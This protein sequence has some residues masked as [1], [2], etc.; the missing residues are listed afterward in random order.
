MGTTPGNP[1]VIAQWNIAQSQLDAVNSDIGGMTNLANEI[2]NNVTVAGF[3]L[4]AIRSSYSL[5]GGIDQDHRDLDQ[6]ENA[7]AESLQASTQM[8]A[9]I[10]AEIAQQAAYVSSERQNLTSL[11]QAIDKGH[12]LNAPGIAGRSLSVG[13]GSQVASTAARRPLVVIRFDRDN[14]NYQNALA[15]AVGQAI[16]RFPSA[17]FDL[18]AISPASA[19]GSGQT[20]R[21]H[22][23]G[24][25]RSL[26]GMGIPAARIT[27]SATSS[28]AAAV[29][30][31]HIYVR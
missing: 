30:E 31:V 17:Q 9:S 7:T 22:A 12:F 29:D 3:L 13:A 26:T 25:M 19:P 6:L 15:S 1:E 21:R 20:A 27:M 10:N 24:V 11:A 18:V 28:P 2:N 8:R 4:D 23:E 14:V 16:Q 5:A